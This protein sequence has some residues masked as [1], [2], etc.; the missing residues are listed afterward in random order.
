MQQWL[1]DPKNKPIVIGGAVAVILIVAIALFMFMG[2]G[3][4]QGTTPSSGATA[5]APTGG[6]PTGGLPE[7]E[8]TASAGPT[9]GPMGP[10]GPM[11]GPMAGGAGYGT[12][13]APQ[14]V[15]EAP[16][17]GKP[18]SKYRVD[19]FKPL[20]WEAD[21]SKPPILSVVPPVRLQP[22]PT[23]KPQGEEEE[24]V[25]PPQPYRRVAGIMWGQSVAAIIETQGDLPRVVKPGDT[26]DGMRVARIEPNQVVLSTLGKKPQEI[27]VKLGA[28]ITPVQRAFPGVGGMPSVPG[29]VPGVPGGGAPGGAG[30]LEEY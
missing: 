15:A 11:A 24:D 9:A 21:L 13:G 4:Q 30:L 12:R 14:Q 8:P 3:G 25:L 23:Y 16:K 2:G 6:T 18:P 26:L 29:G 20:P 1:N 7:D 22:A 19:P 10:M 27:T 5:T 17:D 28:P